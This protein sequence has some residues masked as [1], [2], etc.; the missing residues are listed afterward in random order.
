MRTFDKPALSIP[1]QLDVLIQ[2]GLHV[3]DA[4]AACRYLE[5]ISYFRLSAYMRPFQRPESPDHSFRNDTH[6][7]SIISLYAFDRELRLLV[8]DS[9]E[10]VEVAVRAVLNNTMSI[11]YDS[12]HWYLQRELFKQ[13]YLDQDD[14]IGLIADKM[15]KEKHH[16]ERERKAIETH[17]SLSASRKSSL[18]EKRKQEHYFRHYGLTYDTPDLP[19]GWAMIE[20]LSLGQLS[21]LFAGIAKDRDKKAIC[22]PF[23][24]NSELMSSW[25]HTLTFVRNICAH[26]ARLWNRELAVKPK[27]P[28]SKHIQWVTPD[29]APQNQRIDYTRRLY[30]VLVILNYFMKQISPES[31]WHLRL[32]SLLG[33]CPDN[34]L[35]SMG[36]PDSW[37]HDPFWAFDDDQ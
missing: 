26:H 14:L 13:R 22:R 2:R 3:G 17:R 31:S 33:R 9:I 4:D 19:P 28:T 11:T 1:K 18:I 36:F 24:L 7:S 27:L 37:K 21:R 6:F 23:V 30:V 12:P 32:K 34:H 20:E 8:M 5:V 15:R 25:L 29:R 35:V 10:R 16:F